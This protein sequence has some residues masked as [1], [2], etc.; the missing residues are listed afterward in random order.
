MNAKLFLG[1]GA[2]IFIAIVAWFMLGRNAE[3]PA[4]VEST[5]T[6]TP[7]AVTPAE[8]TEPVSDTFSGVG[9]FL[10]LMKLGRDISCEFS[11]VS[12]DSN[13]AVAGTVQFSGG[14]MRGDFEMQQAGEVY[15]S[16]M[17]QDNDY[18]YTWSESPQG[19][20][21]VKMPV[22]EEGAETT[23]Q[24]GEYERPVDLNNDVDYECRPWGVN[25]SVFTPP[26]DIQF[27][28]MEDM[29]ESM[30][31]GFDPSAYQQ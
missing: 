12:P 13:G 18:M 11:Y 17:I 8:K 29:M 2:A 5:N 26:G 19:T 21:A 25:A 9:S 16:H 22:E 6:E 30:M 10:D 27:R 7:A 14:M 4:T 24:S 23:A 28:S 31:Q 15:T 1:I 3:A 20:F